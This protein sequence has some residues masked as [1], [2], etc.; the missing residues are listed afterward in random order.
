MKHPARLSVLAAALLC[1]A[2]HP[3]LSAPEGGPPRLSTNP[4]KHVIFPAKN[5]TPEQ[6][7]ADELAAYTWA[8]QQTGWDPY[9]ASA[10]LEKAGTATLNQ[11]DAT[12]GQALTGAAAGALVGVTVGAFTGDKSEAAGI[13]AAVGG[14][15]SGMRGRKSRGT[16]EA[17]VSAS[18]VNYQEQFRLWDKHFV[19]AMEGKGYTVK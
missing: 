19:A 3:R 6:Q 9:K 14:L 8:T 12:T 4:A 1:T 17:Q 5:Q 16:A 11:S 15:T 18:V 7:A 2:P 10:E 13:G